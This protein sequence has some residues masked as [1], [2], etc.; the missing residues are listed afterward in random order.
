[1]NVK[2]S[3]FSWCLESYSQDDHVFQISVM[4][5]FEGDSLFANISFWDPEYYASFADLGSAQQLAAFESGLIHQLKT[6]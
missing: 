5:Q 3:E 2:Q 6:T 4:W 1:M